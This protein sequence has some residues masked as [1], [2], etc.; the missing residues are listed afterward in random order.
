MLFNII[1]SCCGATGFSIYELF[2]HQHTG[3][4]KKA[5]VCKVVEYLQ[6]P[7]TVTDCKT[8]NAKPG[9]TLYL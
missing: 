9:C 1:I 5:K 8:N 3:L 6:R 7:Y 4:Y 2:N